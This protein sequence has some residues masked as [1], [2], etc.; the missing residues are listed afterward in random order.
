MLVE[1][2]AGVTF[3]VEL[4]GEKSH[5]ALTDPRG[6]DFALLIDVEETHPGHS[7]RHPRDATMLTRPV[8]AEGVKHFIRWNSDVIVFRSREITRPG[9]VFVEMVSGGAIPLVHLH[10][11]SNDLAPSRPPVHLLIEPIGLED[12]N[13]KPVLVSRVAE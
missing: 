3:R 9:M 6:Y 1:I 11:H 10:A 13:R 4:A 8:L 12:L 2:V 5:L 7:G